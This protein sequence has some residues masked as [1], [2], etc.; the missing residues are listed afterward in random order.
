M[1]SFRP[2]Q[3]PTAPFR[4]PATSDLPVQATGPG[5]V[6]VRVTLQLTVSQSVCLGVEPDLGLLTRDNFFLESYCFVIWGRPLWREVGSVIC[7]SLSLQST[8]VIQYLH[9]LYTICVTHMSYVQY[10]T[11]NV[12]VALYTFT[13]EY[14]KI[15]YLQYIQASFS[16]GF[17]QQIMP[18]LLGI[19]AFLDTWTVVHMTAA[20]FEPLIFF[21]CATE[22]TQGIMAQICPTGSASRSS[23]NAGDCKLSEQSWL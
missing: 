1:S 17:A 14:N 19:T 13:V 20:K 11:L 18:Y 3:I 21:V 23:T 5:R 7:Q 16:P 8:V 22:W 4:A 9:N 10:L 12:Y 15:Q 6:R 2:V